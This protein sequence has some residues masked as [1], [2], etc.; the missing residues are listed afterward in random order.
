MRNP[1]LALDTGQGSPL[2]SDSEVRINN[3]WQSSLAVSAKKNI[4]TFALHEIA[5]LRNL[6]R[7]TTP[8]EFDNRGKLIQDTKRPQ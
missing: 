5:T 8:T 7:G 3:S 2:V 4:I 6:V 1:F